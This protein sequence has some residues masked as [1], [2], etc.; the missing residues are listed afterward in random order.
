[1]AVSIEH[2]LSVPAKNVFVHI[3]CALQCPPEILTAC[4]LK[5]TIHNLSTIAAY[6]FQGS[7]SNS[8]F[9]GKFLQQ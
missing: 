3:S 6:L 4:D 2:Y 1:V 5:V 9:G 8:N 7:N